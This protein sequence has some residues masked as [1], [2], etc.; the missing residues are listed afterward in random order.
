MLF[1]LAGLGQSRGR[2]EAPHKGPGEG[3]GP[4]LKAFQRQGIVF[5]EGRLELVYQGGAVLDEGDLVPAHQAQG[6]GRLVLGQQGPP[7]MAVGAQSIGQGPDVVAVGFVAAGRLALAVLLGGE[8]VNRIKRVTA[9]EQL[10]RGH[11]GRGF[12]GHGA[13]AEGLHL[14]T[15][16]LPSLG[17]VRELKVGDEGPDPVHDDDVMVFFGPI[18]GCIV[19]LFIP[20]SIHST[21]GAQRRWHLERARPDIGALTGRSSLSTWPRGRRRSRQS[22]GNPRGVWEDEPCLRRG[23]LFTAAIIAGGKVIHHLRAGALAGAPH[24]V[25]NNFGKHIREA[26]G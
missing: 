14:Q 16:L 15:E 2:G 19:R 3:F 4:F 12:Y 17:G 20:V 23:Q 26:R 22:W 6:Q 8:R 18:Q 5:A 7:G 24:S 25:V 13:F 1:A 11:A 10:V 9:L 21:S